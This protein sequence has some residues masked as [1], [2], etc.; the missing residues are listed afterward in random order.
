MVHQND[1]LYWCKATSG[2][3]HG[4]LKTT[5]NLL[6]Y[7][8]W[9]S[10]MNEASQCQRDQSQRKVDCDC[11]TWMHRDGLDHCLYQETNPKVLDINDC[12]PTTLVIATNIKWKD[13]TTNGR[14]IC[15]QTLPVQHSNHPFKKTTYALKTPSVVALPFIYHSAIYQFR[16]RNSI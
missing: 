14:H 8:F 4:F 6:K 3:Y 15:R 1:M 13:M 7:C 12:P 5:Q 16:C 10:A 11:T 2:L 9:L